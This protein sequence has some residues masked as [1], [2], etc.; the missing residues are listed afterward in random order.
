MNHRQEVNN[1]DKKKR[2]VEAQSK[3]EKWK[4][5]KNREEILDGTEAKKESR[6]VK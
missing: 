1:R 2:K 4:R 3:G 6:R 5:V